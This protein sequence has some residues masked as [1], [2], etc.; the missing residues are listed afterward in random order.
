MLKQN[1]IAYKKEYMQLINGHKRR[2]DFYLPE[3]NIIIECQGDQHLISRS[4]RLFEQTQD[5]NQLIDIEKYKYC[6]D[7]M[8]YKM[9][10][11]TNKRDFNA[12]LNISELYNKEN[13][14]Y[15]LKKLL[16]AIIQE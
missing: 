2:Y 12:A 5:E 7:E 8:K 13:T 3:Y 15:E 16:N 11:F 6:V 10:Y 14:F 4:G 9:L 1:G